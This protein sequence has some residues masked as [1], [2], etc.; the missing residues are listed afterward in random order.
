MLRPPYGHLSGAALAAAARMRYD[1]ALWSLQM[2]EQQ[3]RGDPAGHARHIID[4]TRPGTI[5]LAHDT[6]NDDR[7]VALKGLPQMI[8]GLRANGFHFV[9]VS[10]LL[11]AQP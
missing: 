2:R 11:T 6:G 3:F 8:D 7:L 1:I 5:L 9:T 4:R 10:T